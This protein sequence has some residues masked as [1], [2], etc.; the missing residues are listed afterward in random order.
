MAVLLLA[1]LLAAGC[2]SFGGRDSDDL[3]ALPAR[4]DQEFQDSVRTFFS[5][6]HRYYIK[7]STGRS[8]ERIRL[9][10]WQT[11]SQDFPVD[12]SEIVYQAI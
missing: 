7:G 5:N 4:Y 12:S 9:L 10:A 11:F 8:V 6:E 3:D 1:V 2:S